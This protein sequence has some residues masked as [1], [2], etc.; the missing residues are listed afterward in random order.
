MPPESSAPSAATEPTTFGSHAVA[1]PLRTSTAARL[2]R[3]A[4]PIDENVPPTTIV[5]RRGWRR[6]ADTTPPTL[7]SQ[8]VAFPDFASTEPRPRRDF[9]PIAANPPPT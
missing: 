8:E 7:G 1:A 5:L 9:P 4:S 2:E 6:I 3:S